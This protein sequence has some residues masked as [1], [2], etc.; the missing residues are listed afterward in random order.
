MILELHRFMIPES[1]ADS[2]FPNSAKIT[3]P[4][5][6]W[7]AQTQGPSSTVTFTFLVQRLVKHPKHTK[8]SSYHHFR[9]LVPWISAIRRFKGSRVIQ[10][11]PTVCPRGSGLTLTIRFHENFRT[12]VKNVT[13]GTLEWTRVLRKT[14]NGPIE[15][16]SWNYPPCPRLYRPLVFSELFTDIHAP[17]FF[18]TEVLK[19]QKSLNFWR[20][21]SLL[22]FFSFNTWIHEFRFAYLDSPKKSF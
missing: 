22:S 3:H 13:L 8:I 16:A 2:R 11:S 15:A 19:L 6:G 9:E 1:F 12:L 5:T 7:K 14:R 18:A 20:Y 21:Y 4:A 17:R 10:S